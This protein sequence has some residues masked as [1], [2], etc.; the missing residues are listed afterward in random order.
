[1]RLSL[2]VFIDITAFVLTPSRKAKVLPITDRL[3]L[4]STQE[5]TEQIKLGK[6]KSQTLVKAYIDRIKSVQPVINAVVDQRYTE[7]LL[8]AIEIDKR[9]LHELYGNDPL[10]PGVSI[11]DQP[12]LGIP[13]SVKNSIGV[14]GMAFDAGHEPRK[15]EKSKTDSKVIQS[16]RK[17]GAIP[18]V[19]T[20]VPELTSWWDSSNKIYGQT[21]NP[22]DL[23]RIPGGSSGGEA[24]L[25]ASAG[26]LIGVGSDTGGS[27]RVPACFCGI[28][29][30]RTTPGVVPTDNQ[31]PAVDAEKNTI[32]S[33]GPMTRYAKDILPMLKVM[34]NSSHKLKLNEDVD[35]SKVKIYYMEDNWNPLETR[36][37]SE[38]KHAIRRMVC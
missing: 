5:L 1:M 16:L 29:G 14:E 26:S 18:L 34:S 17:A 32:L 25:I 20:N 9:V 28:F 12:L 24:A 21:N 6:L 22:Y 36:V 27:I 15:G 35:L 37:S 19:M 23:S 4:Q 3:L 7:A 10:I 31:F 8:E 2:D 13:L 30:H 11:H 38:I 33:V